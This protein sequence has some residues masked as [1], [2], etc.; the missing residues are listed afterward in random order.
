MVKRTPWG[1]I[2]YNCHSAWGSCI[3]E[4]FGL[5]PFSPC[6]PGLFAQSPGM[7]PLLTMMLINTMTSPELPHTHADMSNLVLCRSILGNAETFLKQQHAQCTWN[8][9][10]AH[11]CE[12]EYCTLYALKYCLE[13]VQRFYWNQESFPVFRGIKSLSQYRVN[14]R[15]ICRPGFMVPT[16]CSI[17]WKGTGTGWSYMLVAVHQDPW[18]FKR[19]AMW[20]FCEII[21]P[22]EFPGVPAFSVRFPGV[23][24]F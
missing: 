16:V 18:T 6:L 9:D 5:C 4:H 10:L 3:K 20:N 11:V 17:S 15:N 8:P 1:V 19:L 13:I 22:S 2:L 12:K 7:P 24:A 21:L 23:R 14:P